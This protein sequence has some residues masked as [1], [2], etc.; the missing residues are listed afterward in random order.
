M[1]LSNPFEKLR[2][3]RPENFEAANFRLQLKKTQKN[4]VQ[5]IISRV[6]ML[7]K[8]FLFHK[9]V[10][11]VKSK[12]KYAPFDDKHGTFSLQNPHIA[13]ILQA[14]YEPQKSFHGSKSSSFY[15]EHCNSPGFKSRIPLPN[16]VKYEGGR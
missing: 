10:L 15:C 12:Y 9:Y 5:Y 3:V 16:T 2:K 8:T 1:Q 11:F 6:E 13:N 7:G 14:V 4:S